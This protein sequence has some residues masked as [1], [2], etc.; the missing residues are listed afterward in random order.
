MVNQR[1]LSDTGPGN[2]CNHVN[3][4]VRPC[5]IQERHIVLSTKKIASGNGQS[6]DGNLLGCEP[7]RPFWTYGMRSRRGY[8]LQA[9]TSDST[10]CVDSGRYRWHRFQEF[11]RVLKATPGVFLKESL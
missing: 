5:T 3:I 2:D 1:R 9:L 6:G 8:L 7:S 10:P 11:S 4:L